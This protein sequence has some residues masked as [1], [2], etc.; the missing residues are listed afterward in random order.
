[1]TLEARLIRY[2]TK[3]VYS[4]LPEAAL[5]AARREIL[6]ALGTSVAGAG[7]VAS[8]RVAA[9]VRQQGGREEAT[10]IGFGGRLPAALAGF[11]NGTFAKA[12]EYEDKFWMD[13]AHGYCIGA[14]VVPAAFSIAEHLGGV[15][16]KTFLAAVALA[17]D[18]H[19]RLYTGAPKSLDTGWNATYVFSVFGAAMVAAKLMRLN[20]EQCMNALGL[21]YA[22]MVGNRQSSAEGALAIRMQLGFGIRNG[23]TAAQLAHADIS[24][25][26]H[27]LTGKFGVYS[28][29]F[30]QDEVD[31]D[32]PTR[33]LGYV[34]LGTRL[35]FK[36][37]PCGAVVHPVLDAV[38]SLLDAP[39]VSPDSIE[40][41]QVFGTT[42]LRRMVEPRD[43]CQNPAS[44]VD[45]LFSLPWAVACIIADGKLSLAHFRDE[46]LNDT[47]FRALA[48]KVETDMDD[49]RRSVWVE[50]KLTDGRLLTSRRV[51][52]AKGHPDN[53][54][55][56]QELVE[57]YRDCVRFGPKQLAT[58]HTERAKDMVLHL[59]E[60]PDATEAIRLLA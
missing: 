21:A 52:A 60:L 19:A 12:L 55:S 44:H 2:L 22:Q 25:P 7:A 16:G 45:T 15:D 27:F 51:T 38:V 26:Q 50:M 18:L 10:L 47:R 46:A 31:L 53:P 40:A 3:T 39:G 49:N 6:W 9:F 48:R 56:I 1:M 5:D 13:E 32:A 54:Q 29:I 35:G 28:L 41:V 30:K 14:A 59:Q 42:R 17:T 37:Y 11:A 23:I 58:E 36:A 4:D 34:F 57:K 24:G 8:D 20:E 33:D 43:R